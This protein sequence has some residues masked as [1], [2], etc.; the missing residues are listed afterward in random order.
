M[1]KESKTNNS[2]STSHWK[3]SVQLPR[4]AGLHQ[5]SWLLGKKKFQ[6][7]SIIPLSCSCRGMGMPDPWL[8]RGT[9]IDLLGISGKTQPSPCGGKRPG[10]AGWM[11][12][13]CLLSLQRVPTTAQSMGA[14]SEQG[15]YRF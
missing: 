15:F 12:H 2:F 14:R 13:R 3:V 9:Q 6:T 5:V 7:H 1:C 10:K 4:M 8:P 11:F